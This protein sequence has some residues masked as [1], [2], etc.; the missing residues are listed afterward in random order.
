MNPFD[1]VPENKGFCQVDMSDGILK[2]IVE[3]ESFNAIFSSHY[4]FGAN[5]FV[6]GNWNGYFSSASK[7]ARTTRKS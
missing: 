3:N 2:C 5:G 4:T 7:S 1:D 6:L